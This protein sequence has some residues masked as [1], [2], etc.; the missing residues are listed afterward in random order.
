MMV[1]KLCESASSPPNDHFG[2]GRMNFL[3]WPFL[4]FSRSFSNR[5]CSKSEFS[6]SSSTLSR[7]KLLHDAE[8]NFSAAVLS[9]DVSALEA[10]EREVMTS[11]D[12][13]CFSLS[14]SS[15]PS[16]TWPTTVSSL[17]TTTT[18]TTTSS[19]LDTAKEGC[20]SRG[21]SVT[22][23]SSRWS[24][25]ESVLTGLVE[26]QGEGEAPPRCGSDTVPSFPPPPPLPH[27]AAEFARSR[28]KAV[29]LHYTG[30]MPSTSSLS[31]RNRTF[32]RVEDPLK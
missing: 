11:V 32:S 30:R 23:P 28:D 12:H 16:E 10:E 18:T 19:S 15:S 9:D 2:S 27:P 21:S 24:A 26:A 7:D 1:K 14:T 13:S 5:T 20:E 25:M 4:S 29:R 31:Y 17:T 22:S 6:A 8:G 3:K